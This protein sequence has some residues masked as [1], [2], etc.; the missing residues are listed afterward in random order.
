MLAKKGKNKGKV[1]KAILN[2]S[3]ALVTSYD[4]FLF[5]DNIKL[6]KYLIFVY[7]VNEF[8]YGIV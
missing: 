2:N 1:T 3:C 6:W 4:Q 8:C 7:D 5:W